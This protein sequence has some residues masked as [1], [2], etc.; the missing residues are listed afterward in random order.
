MNEINNA[1]LTLVMINDNYVPGAIALA[2]SLNLVHSKYP[3]ICMVSPSV[4]EKARLVLELLYD[5]VVEVPYIVNAIKSLKGVKQKELYNTWIDKSFTKWNCLNINNLQNIYKL[6]K[7]ILLD[8]DMVIVDNCDD[9]FN[10]QSPAAC[11]SLPW[12]YPYQTKNAMPNLY[13]SSNEEWNSNKDIPHGSE[14]NYKL[15]LFQINSR[16]Q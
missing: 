13:I 10:I 12:A 4:T 2:E 15:I 7:I 11:F 14:I 1:W 5:L 9:L 16:T 6:N 3:K 8:V